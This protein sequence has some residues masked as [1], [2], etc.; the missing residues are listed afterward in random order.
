MKLIDKI[1]IKYFRSFYEKKVE[2]I[3]LKD[4]NIFSGKND[5]G[6]SNILRALNLFFNNE[7]EI[8]KKLI[9]AED[10]SKFKAIQIK[11]DKSKREESAAKKA[12][13]EQHSIISI[14]IHFDLS[15]LERPIKNLPKN[16]WI[17]R[18]WKKNT[19]ADKP[20]QSDNLETLYLKQLKSEGR[21]PLTGYIGRLVHARTLFLKKVRFEYVPAIKDRDFQ[22][23]LFSKVQETILKMKLRLVQELNSQI[24]L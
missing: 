1:E 13:R 5:C 7:T 4:L 21:E 12:A 14:K 6:K 22:N 20:E 10:F 19:E 18:T 2:I 23:Y 9:F 24:P 3:D 11:E 8:G 16:F 17:S 15:S